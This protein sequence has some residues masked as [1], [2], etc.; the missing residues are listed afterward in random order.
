MFNC[1]QNKCKSRSQRLQQLKDQ[2]AREV[3]DQQHQEVGEQQ[4]R[5]EEAWTLDPLRNHIPLHPRFQLIHVE[6]GV[7]FL[8]YGHDALIAESN[9]GVILSIQ[10]IIHIGGFVFL[11]SQLV[12]QGFYLF[13]KGGPQRSRL[14]NRNFLLKLHKLLVQL[15]QLLLRP[16]SRFGFLFQLLVVTLIPRWKRRRSVSRLQADLRSLVGGFLPNTLTR[17]RRGQSRNRRLGRTNAR[18]LR[19]RR[20]V[21]GAAWSPTTLPA[22][23]AEDLVIHS[24]GYVHEARTDQI[25]WC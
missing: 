17:W 11:F 12:T 1:L 19:R 13:L 21:A 3:G 10:P 18:F 6:L 24:S 9:P 25:Y 20:R 2:R 5:E 8:E 14:S 7:F 15:S 23:C 22:H 16:I 4:C